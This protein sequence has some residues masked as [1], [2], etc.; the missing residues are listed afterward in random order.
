MN[1]RPSPMIM[2]MDSTHLAPLTYDCNPSSY[3]TT[4][5]QGGDTRTQLIIV[6]KFHYRTLHGQGTL[7]YFNLIQSH[8]EHFLSREAE[9]QAQ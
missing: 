8:T 7:V 6:D 9:G 1:I 3:L 5:V 4:L 2:K